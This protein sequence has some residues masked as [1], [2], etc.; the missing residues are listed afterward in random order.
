MS[1][2][3]PKPSEPEKTGSKQAATQFKPG[4]SGNPKGKPKGSRNKLGEAFIADLYEDWQEHGL[5]TVQAVRTERPHEY[6]KVVASILPKEVKI[7]RLDDM[8]DD[9]ITKRIRRLADEL[10]VALGFVEGVGGTSG[11]AEEAP[12]PDQAAPLQTLQ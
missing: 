8:T 12:R 4:Q 1:E 3:E 2:S 7:E 9:D 11:D 10:G 6:L 5:A